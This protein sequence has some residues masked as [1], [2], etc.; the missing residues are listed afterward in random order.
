MEY[1]V[2]FYF[3]EITEEKINS[4]FYKRYLPKLPIFAP[5]MPFAFAMLH[6]QERYS[7]LSF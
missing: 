5:K 1:A 4:L 3:D 2:V 6:W 7:R